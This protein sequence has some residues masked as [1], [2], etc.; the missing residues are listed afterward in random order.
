MEIA[1]RLARITAANLHCG[2]EATSTFKAH[3]RSDT[4]GARSGVFD[5]DG[6]SGRRPD[7]AD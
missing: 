3:R 1:M 2:G 4:T 6:N 5:A 7:E